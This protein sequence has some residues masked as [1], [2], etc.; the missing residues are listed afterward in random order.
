MGI[1]GGQRQR[2]LA[3]FNSPRNIGADGLTFAEALRP[4]AAHAGSMPSGYPMTPDAV[5]AGGL[6]MPGIIGGYG[7]GTFNID[8]QQVPAP[9][10]GTMPQSPNALRPGTLSTYQPPSIDGSAMAFD[11][12][13][14]ANPADRPEASSVSR[15]NLFAPRPFT[16]TERIVGI[17]GD[18]LAGFAG[19]PPQFAPMMQ[20][21]QRDEQQFRYA[22]QQRQQQRD[23]QAEDRN[24]KA[25]QPDYFTSGRDRV[26]LNPLT[27]ET[28]VV[29][30]GPEDFDD[31]ATALG[32]E[33]G[34]DEYESAVL[35]YVLRGHGPTALGYDKQLDDYRTANDKGYDDYQTRNRLKV[36]GSP[37]Y[38]DNNPLPPRSGRKPAAPAVK[39]TNPKTGETVILNSRGQWVDKNG[40]PVK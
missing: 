39:A 3:Q 17:I 4:G 10:R 23:W 6:P 11:G 7:G 27:G 35:D 16:K 24:W 38:R 31:Y 5:L 2:A 33:P 19:Q 37:S 22:G 40:R 20:Q 34:S 30:D 15:D 13:V 9:Q 18:A 32:M 12:I 1:L 29:Y 21:R 26:K 8:G 14:P 25:N 36:R 28:Q